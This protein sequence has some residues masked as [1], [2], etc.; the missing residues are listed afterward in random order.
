MHVEVRALFW[1]E[2]LDL[3]RKDNEKS[4]LQHD[5]GSGTTV[6]LQQKSCFGCLF[7]QRMQIENTFYCF[8]VASNDGA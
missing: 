4:T 7:V 2:L 6:V 5:I 1:C 3:D 8:G